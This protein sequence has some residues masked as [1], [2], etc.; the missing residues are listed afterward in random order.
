MGLEQVSATIQG[1]T[2]QNGV[3]YFSAGAHQSLFVPTPSVAATAEM[4]NQAVNYFTSE[5]TDIVISDESVV[6]N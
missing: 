6:A 3:V 5:G 2:T 1:D 4:Q